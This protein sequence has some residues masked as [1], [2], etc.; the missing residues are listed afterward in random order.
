MWPCGFLRYAGKPVSLRQRFLL[1]FCRLFLYNPA[2]CRRLPTCERQMMP[3]ITY[4]ILLLPVAVTGCGLGE[5]K[6]SDEPKPVVAGRIKEPALSVGGQLLTCSEAIEPLVEA[7]GTVVPVLERFKPIAKVTSLDDFREQVRPELRRLII[8]KITA[9]LIEQR[10]R[11]M[12]EGTQFNQH[13]ENLLDDK[14]RDFILNGFNGDSAAAEE[15]LK[16]NGLTWRRFR[17]LQERAIL[18]QWYLSSR[19]GRNNIVTYQE[20]LGRYNQL[21]DKDFLVPAAIKFEL[22]DIKVDQLVPPEPNQSQ[23][24]YAH[25]L[26]EQLVEQARRGANLE[27]LARDRPGVLFVRFSEPVNPRSLAEPYDLLAERAESMKPGEIAGP[28][29]SGTSDH[30]FIMKLNY[31][32]PQRYKTLQEVQKQLRQ[33]IITERRMKAIDKIEAEFTRQANAVLDDRFLDICLE[34]IYQMSKQ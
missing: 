18:N 17:Q 3:K 10:A 27:E 23:L 24:A 32:R 1:D 14:I 2:L 21:K 4:L 16:R 12:L 29:E 7:D 8:N 34:K 28:I 31:L 9:M 26:A 30:V 22:L 25:S 6:L 19:L 13:L 20:L 15:Y 5:P 11:K 33:L